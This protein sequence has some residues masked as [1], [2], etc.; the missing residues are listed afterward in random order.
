M[1]GGSGGLLGGVKELC[2]TPCRSG[3]LFHTR[4]IVHGTWYM[5]YA[6]LLIMASARVETAFAQGLA[7]GL[8]TLLTTTNCNVGMALCAMDGLAAMERGVGRSAH[9]TFLICVLKP[10]RVVKVQ[11]TAV[12]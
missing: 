5:A 6:A 7:H 12:E 11:P 1:I 9:Q 4:Y 8:Q 3:L 10:T 2:V